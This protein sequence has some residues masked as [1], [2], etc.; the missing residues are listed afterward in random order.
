[1]RHTDCRCST[2]SE[3]T[4]RRGQSKS[5]RW[6]YHFGAAIVNWPKDVPQLR[7]ECIS[8]RVSIAADSSE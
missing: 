7:T 2:N 6:T 4:V 3:L 5:M 1:L 8:I